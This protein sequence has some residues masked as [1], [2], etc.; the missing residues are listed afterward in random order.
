MGV[1]SAC[2]F[3]LHEPHGKWEFLFKESSEDKSE[4]DSPD[5]IE[6]YR[7][8]PQLWLLRVLYKS[9]VRLNG[10]KQ[11]FCS[12]SKPKLLDDFELVRDQWLMFFFQQL[13]VSG[14]WFQIF[15]IFTPTWGNDLI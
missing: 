1:S 11:C 4:T 5:V 12:R 14:W 9:S 10:I 8:K 6:T 2:A 3:S 7:K 15:F 13:I